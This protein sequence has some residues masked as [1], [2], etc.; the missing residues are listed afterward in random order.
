MMDEMQALCNKAKEVAT[1]ATALKK[2]EFDLEA[3]KCQ[4]SENASAK[5]SAQGFWK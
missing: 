4:S 2:R 5:Q 1:D 3:E